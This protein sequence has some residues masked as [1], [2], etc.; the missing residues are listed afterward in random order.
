MALS[1]AGFS[2]VL[3][4]V[5]SLLLICVLWGARVVS[6]VGVQGSRIHWTQIIQCVLG[7]VECIILA[8]IALRTLS[9]R[10]R[11]EPLAEEGLGVVMLETATATP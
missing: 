6:T 1:Q 3:S 7:S 5:V 10:K 9:M 2:H 8:I 4:H 11:R